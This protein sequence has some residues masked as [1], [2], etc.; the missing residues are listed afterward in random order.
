MIVCS[1]KADIINKVFTPSNIASNFKDGFYRT[2]LRYPAKPAVRRFPLKKFNP[3]FCTFP[4]VV[5]FSIHTTTVFAVYLLREANGP[6]SGTPAAGTQSGGHH[7]GKRVLNA[8][9]KPANYHPLAANYLYGKEEA[10]EHRL[11]FYLR[12]SRDAENN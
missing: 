2:G 3:V 9:L 5:G 4:P 1:V 10:P 11:I 8:F 12:R 6:G 7:T